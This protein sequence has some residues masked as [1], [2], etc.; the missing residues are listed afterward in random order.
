MMVG[1]WM[2][3]SPGRGHLSPYLHIASTPQLC[4]VCYNKKIH[5]DL[6]GAVIFSGRYHLSRGRC[7]H[8]VADTSN[9][10]L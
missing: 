3:L 2:L 9:L 5:F 1:A 10:P 4:G 7:A 6:V 8:M